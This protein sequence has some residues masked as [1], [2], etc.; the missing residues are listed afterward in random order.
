MR[1]TLKER[2]FN[3]PDGASVHCVG[4]DTVIVRFFWAS[5]KMN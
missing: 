2:S 5:R 3:G 1:T 4:A